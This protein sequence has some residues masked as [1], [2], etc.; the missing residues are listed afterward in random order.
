MGD[1]RTFDE[2]MA[3]L[4]GFASFMPP[5]RPLAWQ[6]RKAHDRDVEQAKASSLMSHSD[7]TGN[8][9][10]NTSEAS[11]AMGPITGELRGKMDTLG[12]YDEDGNIVC[13]TDGE[14]VGEMACLVINSKT[15]GELCDA[16]DAVHR[17]L[18]GE[19]EALR[20]RRRVGG[21]PYVLTFHPHFDWEAMADELDEFAGLVRGMG[22]SGEVPSDG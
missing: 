10:G 6:L 7:G 13:T 20:Q 17:N 2:L 3:D 12:W 18:E 16:I 21:G 22:A 14:P 4:D 15:F 5:L 9:T 19:C 8:G 11:E 1:E